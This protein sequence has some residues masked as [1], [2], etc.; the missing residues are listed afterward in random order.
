[1]LQ[2]FESGNVDGFTLLEESDAVAAAI[3]PPRQLGRYELLGKLGTGGMATVFLGRTAGEAGFQR[4]FAIKVLHSHLASDTGFVKMMLDE[5][6]IAARLHHPNVVPIIDLGAQDGTHYVAME[7]IE[8]CSLSALLKKHRND[9]PAHL[10]VAIFLDILAGLDA[11]HSLTDDDGNSMKLVHRDVSPQNILVGIDGSARITDFGIAR[12]EARINST[13]PGELKGKI[14]YMSPE[15]IK[16]EE[17]DRRS[18]VFAAGG[19]LWSMLTGRRLFQGDNEAATMGNIL[20]MEVP[21]P[22]TLGLQ[23]PAVFD[24]ICLCAL[25]RDPAKRFATAR[26]MEDALR[27][28]A[29][30]EGLLAT[31]REVA[32]WV[33]DTFKEELSQ[34][35]DAIRTAVGGGAVPPRATTLPGAATLTST[36]EF[37]KFTPSGVSE[38]SRSLAPV[39]AAAA[40]AKARQSRP[41]AV[42]IPE[43]DPSDAK[44][45]D[46]A[47]LPP[48]PTRRRGMLVGGAALGALGLVVWL[49][50]R[51]TT[52][53]SPEASAPPPATTTPAPESTADLPPATS[54]APATSPA[55]APAAATADQPP[56][57]YD[58]TVE[59]SSKDATQNPANANATGK[60]APKP[61]QQVVTRPAPTPRPRPAVVVKQ[62]TRPP[63]S[64]KPAGA[65]VTSLRPPGTGTVTPTKPPPTKPTTWDKDSP[66]PPP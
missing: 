41:L 25:Q 38:A 64:P 52:Q 16:S 66:T 1:M 13:R 54:T 15:Q 4:L 34:R 12:A 59:T 22:S 39:A 42:A 30:Q 55:T 18:D 32:A 11:A 50:M 5:A 60:D 58:V 20:S 44:A 23:P 65:D 9:R 7:Y 33:A 48:A 19:M 29:R 17:V 51:S 49:V 10:L 62:P 21:L 28:S 45:A 56:S 26:E 8:G 61:V 37:S 43:A 36:S 46:A 31:R 53:A 57:D 14:A 27:E 47:V 2:I 6:R 40:A 35:R 24:A 3:Q 63:A